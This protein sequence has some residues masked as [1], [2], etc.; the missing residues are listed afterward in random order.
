MI[1]KLALRSGR[2]SLLASAAHAC[3]SGLAGASVL[4]GV[5]AGSGA[6]GENAAPIGPFVVGGLA[7]LVAAILLASFGREAKGSPAE[8]RRNRKSGDAGYPYPASDGGGKSGK[9]DPDGGGDGGGGG[10]AG[11]D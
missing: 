3:A 6:G 8:V 7:I 4:F 11:G 5:A 2:Q 1:S 9:A 10:G